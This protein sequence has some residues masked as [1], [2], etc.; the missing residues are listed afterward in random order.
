[1][2]TK[3]EWFD[4]TAVGRGR[5]PARATFFAFE[6]TELALKRAAPSASSRFLDLNGTWKFS[7]APKAGEVP[8]GFEQPSY[9]DSRWGDIPVP[10]NWEL[11]GYGFPI[12][13]NVDY[14][15]ETDP[16]NI[17]Y[18]GDDKEY[19]PTGVYRRAF[20]P[21][22]AWFDQGH[23][24]FLHIGSVCCGCKVWLNGVELGYS[25]DS[26][27]PVEFKL[28]PHLK[29]G[30]NQLAMEVLC[31]SSQAYL[32]DQDM[33]WF[34][35]INRDVYVYS[36]PP[37]HI[38]DIEVRAGADG[39]LEIDAELTG[40]VVAGASSGLQLHC[41]L[42]SLDAAGHASSSVAKFEAPIS[43]RLDGAAGVARGKVA[44]AN[45]K[46]WSSETPV[47]YSL[48]VKLPKA[49]GQAEVEEALSVRVGFRTVEIR[50]GRLLLNGSEL[51]VRGVNRHEHDCRKGHVVDR[52]TM[53]E[54][55]RLMKT[56]NFNSVRCSHYPNDPLW[57]ELCDEHGLFVVDE[58]NI[59]SHGVGFVWSKTL[60]NQKEWGE[61]HMVR[62]QRMLERDKNHPSI[63]IWSLGN[64]AGNGINHHRTYMWL[65]RRDPT[66]PVQYENARIEE[67]WSTEKMETIDTD[68][69]IY[70]PMYPSQAKLAR[71][72]QEFEASTKAHPCIMCE[73]AHAMGNTLGGFKEYWDVINKYDVLQGGFIWDWVDQGIEKTS[74]SG[75][76]FWAYG[77]DYGGPDTPS[78]WNFCCNG[79]IQP[80]RKPSPHLFEAK[81]CQQPVTFEAEAEEVLPSSLGGTLTVTV[82]NRFSF[83][84]L[85]HLE[86][87]WSVSADGAV[88]HQQALPP[89]AVGPR[90]AEK[91]SISLP[92]KPSSARP[93][94]EYHFVIRA[95]VRKGSGTLL[96]PEGHEVAWEQWAL[97]P[98][99]SIAPAAP[100][101]TPE[102]AVA[103]EGPKIFVTVGKL[104]A[105]FDSGTGLLTGLASNGEELLAAPLSLNFWRPP[106]DNDYGAS[107]Q[108]D[109]ASWREAGAKA[110]PAGPM[111]VEPSGPGRVR[112]AASLVVGSGNILGL[113][114]EVTS[115][116][117]VH[118]GA[119]WQP[120]SASIVTN[121][122]LVHAKHVS[123]NKHVDVEGP[124]VSARWNDMGEWQK[125]TLKSSS[126]A[127]GAPLCHGDVVALEATTGKTAA[128]L[129][130]N[131]LVPTAASSGGGVKVAA[132][133]KLGEEV[134]RLVRRAGPGEVK[135]QDE[136]YF[137]E[138]GQS[139]RRLTV[140]SQE[141]TTAN[142]SDADAVF[143]LEAKSQ[144]AP[145][146][147]GLRTRLTEGLEEVEWFGRGPH[148]SYIDRYAS[149]RVGLFQG[150]I[151]D[152][153]F[154][155]VRPQ[156]NGNKL[157]TRWM[158]LRRREG[159]SAHC[160][161][162]LVV[163]EG[164]PVAMQCHQFDL[165][166]FDGPE[167]KKGQAVRHGG[168][169][170]EKRE[171]TLCVDAAQ[172]GVGGIDS[173]GSKPLQEHMIDGQRTYEWSFR[174]QP[175]SPEEAL[176][177]SDVLRTLVRDA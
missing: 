21:P 46:T 69:D 32:E 125:L 101:A 71:Y 35:G 9:D 122:Q 123:S 37:R 135:L 106:T 25:T 75:L 44:V 146:R 17:K 47:L 137:E 115:K 79:L 131:S 29:R 70:C 102:P 81:K 30:T 107:L 177:G 145:P 80:D 121:G 41:E 153:T 98:E 95:V 61:S 43:G 57:Y 147:I 128:E 45:V 144:V 7:W 50:Q 117:Y 151:R 116:G 16:P 129:L 62:V 97:Q 90:G 166:D 77:S 67:V 60:G 110:K 163:A 4:P 168:E 66:R 132:S 40:A 1:M 170:V 143:V 94:T 130:L 33:F 141:V 176:A 82:R 86:L 175:L 24:V 92:S 152:Q 105:L 103:R 11:N 26:K 161:G 104:I 31:W 3:S 48:V 55:I 126:K 158:T 127:P 139:L 83:L 142:A 156:E 89:L 148:E 91:L 51:T 23:E 159:A 52:E 140:A 108:R 15:F 27:L 169:L 5:E 34:A 19:N 49:P 28:T 20:E 154:R 134:W 42:F 6:S 10:G 63:I 124:K 59:E 165:A 87:S 113:T 14:I 85:E 84:S 74:D 162:L 150:A 174:L 114:Y 155:Y 109:L 18:R 13:T 72:G 88:F 160:G 133:G 149:A 36:R 136:L 164:R 64:E 99:A 96:V 157:D 120:G 111:S 22:L 100:P 39:V 119:R 53:L 78:D 172:M 56:H 58:A 118:V 93:G 65:K 173:W 167:D 73:Y 12:Y 171:T 54:D 76:K 112:L 68:T 138:V 2:A 38:R 8:P